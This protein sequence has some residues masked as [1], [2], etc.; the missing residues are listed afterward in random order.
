MQGV[1][2][3]QSMTATVSYEAFRAWW[4]VNKNKGPGGGPLGGLSALKNAKSAAPTRRNWARRWFVIEG[5]DLVYYKDAKTA[6]RRENERGRIKL[7][8]FTVCPFDKNSNNPGGQS[9]G[10]AGGGGEA[11]ASSSS[12]EKSGKTAAFVLTDGQRSM[13]LAAGERATR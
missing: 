3:N 4:L 8:S 11:D 2:F 9:G 13:L 10:G 1:A 5:F 6:A 7:N 12:I